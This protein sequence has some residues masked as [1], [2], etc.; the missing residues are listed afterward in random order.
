[1]HAY[2][3]TFPPVIFTCELFK[4]NCCDF[5]RIKLTPGLLVKN[6]CF[7]LLVSRQILSSSRQFNSYSCKV[8]ISSREKQVEHFVGNSS[9]VTDHSHEIYYR[10]LFR[11]PSNTAN[12]AYLA[13]WIAI[14]ISL[15]LVP[16]S[17]LSFCSRYL[18]WIFKWFQFVKNASDSLFDEILLSD[19]QEIMSFNVYYHLQFIAISLWALSILEIT[20]E[21]KLS[22]L[23]WRI[24]MVCELNSSLMVRYLRVLSSR[25]NLAKSVILYLDTMISMVCFRFNSLRYT[26][27]LIK[28]EPE[29]GNNASNFIVSPIAVINQI[30]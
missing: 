19:Y 29:G 27:K 7:N 8:F 21:K 16:L 15:A 25:I 1:M 10:Q 12:E 6:F 24:V 2:M 14:S 30:N 20:R 17:L 28:N 4:F 13:S 22:W 23:R 26:I 3:H 11:W 18:E 5:S 9:H